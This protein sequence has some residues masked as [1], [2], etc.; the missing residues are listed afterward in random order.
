MIAC[1]VLAGRK[2][3]RERERE[4]AMQRTLILKY[5]YIKMF[6]SLNLF[7]RHRSRSQRKQQR[8]LK[9]SLNCTALHWTNIKWAQ[10]LK[11]TSSN[12]RCVLDN[13]S[14]KPP[15]RNRWSWISRPFEFYKCTGPYI[16]IHT[17][18]VGGK[19][20][21]DR[22]RR[23]TGTTASQQAS[24]QH[25]RRVENIRTKSRTSRIDTST[26]AHQKKQCRSSDKFQS[27]NNKWHLPNYAN[28]INK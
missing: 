25:H 14:L 26:T 8:A 11:W 5:K 1:P 3:E 12:F 15:V 27:T 19:V 13:S 17:T 7:P 20:G 18:K 28:E 2:R 4:I 9:I 16:C 6:V 10:G 23:S 21:W 22:C 24:K